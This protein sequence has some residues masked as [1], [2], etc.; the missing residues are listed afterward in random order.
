M[1]L[2]MTSLLF[3]TFFAILLVAAKS[4]LLST[5]LHDTESF[6]KALV[7]HVN[8]NVVLWIGSIAS[9]MWSRSLPAFTTILGVSLSF[10][11]FVLL[12]TAYFSSAQPLLNN[13]VP[14]FDDPRYFIGILLILTSFLITALQWAVNNLGKSFTRIG[15]NLRW[16]LN[17]MAIQLFSVVLVLTLAFIKLDYQ[18]NSARYFEQLLWGPGHI[19]QLFSLQLM[20]SIWAN[21]GLTSRESL[22]EKFVWVIPVIAAI[23]ATLA[24][25]IYA[26]DS[27][28][29]RNF[30]TQ[31]MRIFSFWVLPVIF[32]ATIWRTT[33]LE[34]RIMQLSSGLFIFG[35]L[36][37]LL[38]RGDNL[39]I[40]AHYHAVTGAINLSMMGLV[41][42]VV[43]RQYADQSYVRL[44]SHFYATSVALLAIGLAWSGSM[45]GVR[46]V[47]LA[48]QTIHDWQH[49]MV[50]GLMGFGGILAAIAIFLFMGISVS[51]LRKNTFKETASVVR[52]QH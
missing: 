51:H 45:G 47:T 25:F 12:I 44:Q 39:M 43:T 4:P 6:Q 21:F 23:S 26:P 19:W 7:L 3:A 37:G 15:P 13:Y 9:Y 31:H 40:P 34:S 14:V 42:F 8:L 46:K 2:G 22:I 29:Y 50:L 5:L 33:Q 30:Y 52:T 17:L 10:T 49:I 38:I 41:L 24:A 18:S 1:T 16:S 27:P 36:I 35:A 20:M 32:S 48:A 28:E 11:G